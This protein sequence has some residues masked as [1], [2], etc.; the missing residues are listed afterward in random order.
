[1]LGGVCLVIT[2]AVYVPLGYIADRV[3]GAIP[4]HTVPPVGLEPTL[5]G[6]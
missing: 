5:G 1:M 4:L 2:T 3:L 6:F